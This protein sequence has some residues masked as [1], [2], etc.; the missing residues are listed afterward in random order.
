[1]AHTETFKME[2]LDMIDPLEGHGDLDYIHPYLE[3]SIVS[4]GVIVFTLLEDDKV[5]SIYGTIKLWR[6]VGDLFAI[7]CKDVHLYGRILYDFFIST[8]AIVFKAMDLVRLQSIVV[9]GF[10]R[11]MRFAEGIGFER[12][13]IM[14][15]W[16]PDGRDVYIYS[17]LKEA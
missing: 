6:G 17:K 11:G 10:E 2:H 8:M 13:G 3:Q 5:I 1:M 12:E 16:S 4:G 9:V 7:M 14:R 15:R